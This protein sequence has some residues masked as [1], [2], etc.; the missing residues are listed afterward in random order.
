MV[1]PEAPATCATM[2]KQAFDFVFLEVMEL[3]PD[4]PLLKGLNKASVPPS[5]PAVITLTGTQIASIQVPQDTDNISDEDQFVDAAQGHEEDGRYTSILVNAT[6]TR[7]TLCPG[8]I[9]TVLS[10]SGV[11][12]KT[13]PCQANNHETIKYCVSNHHGSTT[14]KR[15]AL[16]DH[17]TSG[18]LVRNDVRIMCTTD[19]EVDVS[20]INN[21]QMPNLC[22]VTAG[23]VVST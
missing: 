3:D 23:G 6:K 7:L 8:D 12:K 5:I 20:G 19:R 21:Y 18:G 15:G 17:G 4:D 11:N 14:G 9:C 13:S 1:V 16:V 22:I 10:S 2:Q